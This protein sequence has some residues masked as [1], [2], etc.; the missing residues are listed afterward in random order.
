MRRVAANASVKT[1]ALP[2][3][4][5]LKIAAHID[6]AEAAAGVRSSRLPNPAVYADFGAGDVARL[7]RGEKKRQTCDFLGRAH[8]HHGDHF[9]VHFQALGRVVAQHRRINDAWKYD[10]HTNALTGKLGG[11]ELAHPPYGPFRRGIGKYAGNMADPGIRGD[12]DNG[13]APGSAHGI[14]DG[15]HSEKHAELVYPVVKVP[16]RVVGLRQTARAIYPRIVDQNVDSPE[17]FLRRGDEVTPTCRIGD[18]VPH[19][20]H[21]TVKRVYQ[22][23]I[24]NIDVGEHDLRAFGGEQL[25]RRCALPS[26]PAGD[27]RD[28]ACETRSHDASLSFVAERS[29]AVLCA[30]FRKADGEVAGLFIVR[31]LRSRGRLAGR[32]CRIPQIRHRSESVAVAPS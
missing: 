18:I 24:R 30:R 7:I 20:M 12:I 32:M 10:I 31:P 29:R 8:A 25:R 3:A 22:R 5:A 19:E 13:A 21:A 15:S 1:S 16:E 6:A 4:L 23:R 26:A 11:R 2:P 28:L 17:R 27:N 14:D 9:S